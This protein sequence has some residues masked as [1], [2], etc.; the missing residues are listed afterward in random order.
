MMIIY[1]IDWRIENDLNINNEQIYFKST[2]K[3]KGKIEKMHLIIV[4][5]VSWNVCREE[6]KGEE[7]INRDIFY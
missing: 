2:K 6:E 4:C 1:Q 5:L 3:K 7:R